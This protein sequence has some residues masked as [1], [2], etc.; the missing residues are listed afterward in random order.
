MR[1][2]EGGR[3]IV[4]GKAKRKGEVYQQ[5]RGRF[6]RSDSRGTPRQAA[7]TLCPCST[8]GTC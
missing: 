5:H 4:G 1:R 3:R 7:R 2:D 8:P 6:H